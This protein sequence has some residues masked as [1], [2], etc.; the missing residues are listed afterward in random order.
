MYCKYLL[1]VCN[2]VLLTLFMVSFS[3]EKLLN[4]SYGSCFLYFLKKSLFTI[5]FNKYKLVFQKFYS[6][7]STFK[8][9]TFLNLF[10]LWMWGRDVWQI[11]SE[12]C[13]Y[14]LVQ[15]RASVKKESQTCLPTSSICLRV[16]SGCWKRL[17][18]YIELA[19]RDRR[20]TLQE[21]SSTN[22]GKEWV[23]EYLPHSWMGQLWG[24][25]HTVSQ[26]VHSRFKP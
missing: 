5:R 1:Q 11:S 26:G 16:F 17:G 3:K 7:F 21:W 14:P 4:F 8:L 15:L 9:L 6:F 24:M 2:I 25:F 10:F 22:E 20:P 19:A 13:P 23:E 18:P 12:L